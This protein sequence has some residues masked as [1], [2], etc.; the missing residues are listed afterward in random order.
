MICDLNLNSFAGLGLGFSRASDTFTFWIH[1]RH[2]LQK[3]IIV[4]FAYIY[5]RFKTK[6]NDWKIDWLLFLIEKHNN[7]KT[8]G[9]KLTYIM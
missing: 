2:F 6:T 5:S 4:C 7:N 3:K 9:N 8:A 1:D